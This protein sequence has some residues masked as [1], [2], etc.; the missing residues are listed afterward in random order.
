MTMVQI[1]ILKTVASA[2]GVWGPGEVVTVDPD[3]AQQWCVA[4]IAERVHAVPAA[5]SEATKKGAKRC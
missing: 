5:P 1:Q 2:K 3:T 4:G